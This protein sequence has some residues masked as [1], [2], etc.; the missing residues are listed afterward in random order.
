MIVIVL[1]PTML[2]VGLQC[3]IV[4]FPGQ[5]HLFFN[6]KCNFKISGTVAFKFYSDSGARFNPNKYTVLLQKYCDMCAICRIVIL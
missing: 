3:V 4:V 5:T 2:F 1:F 6:D